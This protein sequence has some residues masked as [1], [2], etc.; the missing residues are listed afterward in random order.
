[1]DIEKVER[2]AYDS[3][4]NRKEQNARE[5]GWLYYHGHRT[6]QIAMWLCETLQ[7]EADRDEVYVGALFH[8]IGKGSEEHNEAGADMARSLLADLCTPEE[9]SG[10]C[11]VIRSHNQRRSPS[12]FS[13]GVKIVQDADLI[14]HVGPVVPWLAFYWSGSHNETIHDHIRFVTSEDND[15]YRQGMRN[16]LNFDVSR[17]LFDERIAYEDKFFATFHRVY[18]EGL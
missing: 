12:E 14:D 17:R 8:D 16:A 5:P 1:M 13:A 3:M 7:A 18:F 2:V 10:T 4:A 15:R 9:L 6:A 11:E